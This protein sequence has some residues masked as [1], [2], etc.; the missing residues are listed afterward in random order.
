MPSAL[1]HCWL[2]P[3]RPWVKALYLAKGCLLFSSSILL[4]AS[5]IRIMFVTQHGVR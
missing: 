4:A 1:V 3:T 5:S 2:T